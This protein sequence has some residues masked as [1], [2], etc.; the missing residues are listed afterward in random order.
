MASSNSQAHQVAECTLLY[1]ILFAFLL[2]KSNV[3]NSAL[4]CLPIVIWL[5]CR[6][7]QGFPSTRPPRAHFI[8][9]RLSRLLVAQLRSYRIPIQVYF[10]FRGADFFSLSSHWA[11][12]L[13]SISVYR[14]PSVVSELFG[15]REGQLTA[16]GQSPSGSLSSPYHSIC[17]ATLRCYDAILAAVCNPLGLI[18]QSTS[19][20]AGFI[21]I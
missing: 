5:A 4:R 9:N 13:P 17:R 3:L 18:W 16:L 2:I 11:W 1:L 10:Q 8:N 6:C 12:P 7:P 14:I 21:A 15:Q 20:K 19:Q